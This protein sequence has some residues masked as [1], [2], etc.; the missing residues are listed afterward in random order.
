V[1]DPLVGVGAPAVHQ[2]QGV[3]GVLGAVLGVE[4]PD[5]GQGAVPRAGAVPRIGTVPQFGEGHRLAPA[6][7]VGG[8]SERGGPAPPPALRKSRT[9]FSFCSRFTVAPSGAV[10]NRLVQRV[11]APSGGASKTTT[12]RVASPARTRCTASP[13]RS[14]GTQIGRHTSELQSRENLVCR[15]LL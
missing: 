2:E 6:G 13:I 10:I 4:Q 9:C 11:G 7:S 15:L 14:S 1:L 8:R 5:V 3:R 12:D